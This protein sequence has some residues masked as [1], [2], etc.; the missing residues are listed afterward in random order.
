MK[1]LIIE[2]ANKEGVRIERVSLGANDVSIGRAWDSDLIIRDI[3]VDPQHL[4]LSLNHNGQIQITDVSSTN[5]TKLLGKQVRGVVTSYCLGDALTIGDTRVTLFDA[6]T[7]VAP[8][9]FRSQW[10]LMAQRFSSIKTLSVLTLLSLLIQ[11][12]QSYSRSSEPLKADSVIVTAFGV[13]MLL[14]I[15]SLVLGFVAKLIRAESNFKPLWALGCLAIIITN[16]LTTLL[17]I[18]QFNLQDI[19]LGQALV[20]VVFGIFIVWLL[21]GI[22][23]YTTHFQRRSKWI[24]SLCVAAGL[25]GASE[26]DEF[27]KKPHQRWSSSTQTEQSTLP[28]AFLFS[29][30]V[31]VDEYLNDVESLFDTE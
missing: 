4:S 2:V 26:S 11:G 10:F 8:T 18:I 5:G 19:D 28:P 23:S 6:Q 14:L 12:A 13:L 22:F 15:W 3:F 27:L 17:L 31:S 20:V 25:Y 30:G 24:C 29:Q 16:I 7:S 21:V 1:K 9:S